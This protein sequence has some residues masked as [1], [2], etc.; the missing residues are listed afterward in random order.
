MSNKVK[1]KP[2]KQSL[3][4]IQEVHFPK[5]D[6]EYLQPGTRAYKMGPCQ[7]L[8]S[9]MPGSGMYHM[10]ISTTFRDPTWHEIAKAWYTLVPDAANRQA[11][12]I[13]P[14]L[15]DYINL[16]QF[17]FQVHELAAGALPDTEPVEMPRMAGMLGMAIEALAGPM[18]PTALTGGQFPQEGKQGA[19]N[20]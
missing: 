17:C 10:S 13:L 20:R 12:M 6:M 1:K 8:L 9:Q 2:A 15:E 5:K 4:P 7:I 3:P 11:A 19:V 16:H 14:K 18:T